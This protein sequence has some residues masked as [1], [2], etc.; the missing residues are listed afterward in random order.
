MF[1]DVIDCKSNKRFLRYE[2]SLFNYEDGKVK[3]GNPVSLNDRKYHKPDTV[4]RHKPMLAKEYKNFEGNPNT[5]VIGWWMSEKYDGYRA[6]WNGR[7]FKSRT[8]NKF[9]VPRWFSHMMPQGIALDGEL[10]MGRG[11]FDKCGLFRRIRPKKKV[12]R[13]IW[14]QKWAEAG[15][16]YKVFDLPNSPLI[17][18]ERMKKLKNIIHTQVTSKFTFKEDFMVRTFPLEFTE[19]VKISSRDQLENK[20]NSVV[21][22]NGEGLILRE[23]HSIYE[24]R[25]SPSMLKYKLQAD[26]ECKIVGYKK[27]SGVNEGR[28]GSFICEFLDKGIQF[29]VGGMDTSVRK[30]YK[31][32]HKLGT[33]ITIQYNGFTSGEKPRHPRYLRRRYKV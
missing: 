25:R 17:F 31:K 26:M 19:Q 32:T 33:V 30:S 24:H 16:I 22:D 11:N 21:S 20:F 8:N 18:E 1:C 9:C 2:N 27:G 23:P 13:E 12:D 5:N 28:L 6:I 15:V 29:T 4:F 14:E 3:Q 10:W 7:C